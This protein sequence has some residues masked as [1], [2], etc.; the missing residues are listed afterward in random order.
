MGVTGNPFWYNTTTTEYD[1]N[2]N[3]DAEKWWSSYAECPLLNID[4]PQN[5]VLFLFGL[6]FLHMRM[7]SVSHNIRVQSQI[8]MLKQRE[9]S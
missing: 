4:T 3:E 9:L 5:Q 8:F 2:K 1:D 7:K 6:V